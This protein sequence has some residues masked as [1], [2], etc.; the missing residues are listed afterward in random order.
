MFQVG[1]TEEEEEEEEEE[2]LS[3][4]LSI[5]L[6]LFSPCG[7][8]PPFQFLN[9]YTVGGTPWTRDQ[10]VARPLPIQRTAQTQNKRKQTSMPQLRFE[11]TIP[12][13]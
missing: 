12:M 10:P 8:W 1:A 9:Q 3:I 7:P 2:E 11:P 6:W 5:Y 4:Y 13:F